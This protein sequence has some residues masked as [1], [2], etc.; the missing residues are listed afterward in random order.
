MSKIAQLTHP[1]TGMTFANCVATITL[2]NRIA[3]M[4]TNPTL[5][6]LKRRLK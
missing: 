5:L 1:I 6:I 2:I 4:K 3:L